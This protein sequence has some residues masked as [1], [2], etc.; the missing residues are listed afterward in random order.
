[1]SMTEKLN[2]HNRYLQILLGSILELPKSSVSL[3]LCVRAY[4]INHILLLYSCSI[5]SC[6]LSFLLLYFLQLLLTISFGRLSMNV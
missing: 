3:S 5:Y 6:G 2:M 1:M 4:A